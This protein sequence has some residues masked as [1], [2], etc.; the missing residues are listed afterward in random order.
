M[1]A[2]TVVS[3]VELAGYGGDG[4]K[5]ALVKFTGSASYDTGGSVLDLSAY[6][7]DEVR[8]I[9]VTAQGATGKVGHYVPDSGNAPATCKVVIDD[10][11][12]QE[13]GSAGL[14]GITFDALVAGTDA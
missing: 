4:V 7:G 6:F 2:H 12:T 5:L 9:T 10:G 14:S 1:S 11:G 13:S 8:S 3:V